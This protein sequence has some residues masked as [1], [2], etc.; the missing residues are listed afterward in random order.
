MSLERWQTPDQSVYG[1]ISL[2][3]A[4]VS[5]KHL[6]EFSLDQLRNTNAPVELRLH[7]MRLV[8]TFFKTDQVSNKKAIDRLKRLANNML[9]EI[10][11]S[12]LGQA[13]LFGSVALSPMQSGEKKDLFV[14]KPSDMRDVFSAI[15]N[16]INSKNI[17][18][19]KMQKTIEM[20]LIFVFFLQCKKLVR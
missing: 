14:G 5:H 8:L 3:Y 9:E 19:G 1:A 6:Y 7:A 13:Q 17:E 4:Q 10:A 12:P 16:S 2:E 11:D 18:L 20:L 15:L